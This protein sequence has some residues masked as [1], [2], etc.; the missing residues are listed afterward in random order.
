MSYFVFKEPPDGFLPLVEV[1]SFYC[2]WKD[3]ILFLK[4]HALKPQGGTW[5]VPA[6]KVEKGELPH[7][8][9][10]REVYEEIGVIVEEV[11]KI[12]TLFIRI[13]RLDYVYHMFHQCF[14][15]Q[16]KLELALE[17]HVEA[18]WVTF[19]EAMELP[20]IAGGKEALLFY[21]EYL[22]KEGNSNHV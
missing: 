18:R 15:E 8:T 3:K 20:L 4:R 5:G 1:S 13:P 21:K 16:P 2:M 17:E 12:G 14:V 22:D 10:K 9:L 11:E 6:G 7:Q 19:L